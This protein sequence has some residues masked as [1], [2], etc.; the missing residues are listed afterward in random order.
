MML[1]YRLHRSWIRVIFDLVIPCER[2]ITCSP[3]RCEL[4]P[5]YRLCFLTNVVRNAIL[6]SAEDVSGFLSKEKSDRSAPFYQSA[7][8][9]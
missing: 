2:V 6:G 7:E 4:C 8:N 3:V 5:I 1:I 9:L